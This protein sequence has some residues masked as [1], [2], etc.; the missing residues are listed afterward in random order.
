MNISRYPCH[1]QTLNIVSLMND[2]CIGESK[3]ARDL[4]DRHG[5]FVGVEI[6]RAVKRDDD[7]AP[8]CF[9]ANDPTE[10]GK[11]EEPEV[12]LNVNEVGL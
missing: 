1:R 7:R 10:F 11:G 6:R 8:W 3:I 5:P 4:L 12:V 9:V 2:H